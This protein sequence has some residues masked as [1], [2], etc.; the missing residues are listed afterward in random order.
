MDPIHVGRQRREER[1][2]GRTDLT[3]KYV[4]IPA[5]L[6][7]TKETVRDERL[8]QNGESLGDEQY[9]YRWRWP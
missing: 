3:R 4:N 1:E 7:E 9:S 6:E 2:I 5:S 8:R